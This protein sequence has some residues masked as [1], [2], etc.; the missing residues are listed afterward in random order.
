MNRRNFLGTV[1]S[2]LVGIVLGS[3]VPGCSILKPNNP[4]NEFRL[5][6]GDCD[7][8][9][10]YGDGGGYESRSQT[11]LRGEIFLRGKKVDDGVLNFK[12]RR[13]IGDNLWEVD[14]H[15]NTLYCPEFF[16]EVRR[17]LP[18]LAELMEKETFWEEKVGIRDVV[19][20]GKVVALDFIYNDGSGIVERYVPTRKGAFSSYS[21]IKGKKIE[22][23]KE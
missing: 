4:V 7:V 17:K 12:E 18:H 2:G 21:T 9:G 1:G 20:E 13:K 15:L 3:F 23:I 11:L 22:D 10:Y 5:Y 19:S 6:W 14:L 16:N 8:S